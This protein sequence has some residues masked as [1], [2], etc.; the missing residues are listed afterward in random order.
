MKKNQGKY[1]LVLNTLFIN[2]E[3]KYKA[4]QRLTAPCGTYINVGLPDYTT[5]FKIDHQH[6]LRNQVTIAGSLVGIYFL[7]FRLYQR[8]TGMCLV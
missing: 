3:E 4:H 1:D 5:K 8:S 6:L 7:I 2:D